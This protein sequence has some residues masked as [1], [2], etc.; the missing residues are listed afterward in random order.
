MGYNINRKVC[1]QK[2]IKMLL[3]IFLRIHIQGLGSHY[4]RIQE[5]RRQTIDRGPSN[6]NLNIKEKH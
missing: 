2:K 1:F 6:L 3:R 4:H 5:E